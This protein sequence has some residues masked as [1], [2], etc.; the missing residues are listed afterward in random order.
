MARSYPSVQP[1]RELRA[2]LSQMRLED[3]A[4][5]WD[6]R[7]RC[8][9][10]AFRSRTGRNQP[11]TTRFIFGPAVWLR[12][13]IRPEPGFGLA[14]L[15]WSQQEF[16]IAAA[17]SRDTAMLTAYES[18]DPYLA[19]ARQAGAVPVWA[20]KHTHGP[21]RE[22]F[23]ACALAVQYGMGTDSLAERIARPTV[24]A[25]RL[26]ELHRETFPRFWKWSDAAVDYAMLHGSIHTVFGWAF[27][28]GP[29]T[30]PRTLRNFPMQANGAEMLRLAC[31]LSSEAGVR[32]CA[33][34]H[35][36]ILIEAPL[37]ELDAAVQSAQQAMSD[38]S[39]AVLGG[40][41][42]RSDS[43][44]ARYPDRYLDERGQ[45]M[46]TTVTE[47]I[48]EMVPGGLG[49]RLGHLCAHE[50]LPVHERT[51]GPSIPISSL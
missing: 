30:N 32:L 36:A 34:V 21:V 50:A 26:L 44:V 20:T 51:P 43:K 24:E 6:G 29:N 48:Q 15:D 49:D 19:F 27:H 33:P 45:Q 22:L 3:L 4:V 38:A 5:G 46:W 11:S 8:L 9:L 2:T 35:D 28:V 39:A 16:G 7:N 31:C 14:Y 1:I 25:R 18:G 17:L 37:E 47:L 23:K 10:S 40:F 13:L 42:L 12:G 41:R